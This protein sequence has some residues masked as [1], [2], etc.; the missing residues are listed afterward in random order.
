MH[1]NQKGQTLLELIVVMSVAVMVVG[2]LVFA[3]I[4]SLR[5]AQFAKNQAQA[6]K[7]AQDGLEKVRSLRDRDTEGSVSYQSTTSKFSDLWPIPFTCGAGGNCYFHFNSS[8]T[9]FIGENSSQSIPPFQ[10]QFLIED[11]NGSGMTQKRVT[12][13]VKWT[14]FSGTHESR[15]TTIL[16]RIQ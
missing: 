6:T 4:S 13:V 2:A 16:R 7:L 15:L 3:T 10:R 5:N 12:S 14:D 9:I 1:S 11:E 8:E